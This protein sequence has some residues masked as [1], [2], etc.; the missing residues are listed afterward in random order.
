MKRILL[1]GGIGEARQLAHQL[2]PNHEVTYSLAGRTSRHFEPPCAV[3][4]GGFGG[5]TGLT[6]FLENGRFTLVIDATHPYAARISRHAVSAA[7]AIGI[8]VWAYRRPPWQ[9]ATGVKWRLVDGWINLQTALSAFHRPFF[10]VGQEPLNHAESIPPAQHWLVRCLAAQAPPLP[11]LIVLNATGPFT[12]EDELA[13]MQNYGVDVLVSKNSGGSAVA[14][15]LEAARS[16]EI[17]V[18]MLERPR[19]PAVDREFDNIVTLTDQLVH[20]P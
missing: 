10:T 8:P 16:L 20:H 19:L 13:V 17:P 2:A 6:E 4:V 9:P 11:N 12:V 14:A 7:S 3:S 18:L 5:V 15:K 1:L